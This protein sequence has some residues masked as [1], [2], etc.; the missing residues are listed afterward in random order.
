MAYSN[1]QY[2][3]VNNNKNIYYYYYLNMDCLY[4]SSCKICVSNSTC[5]LKNK[6]DKSQYKVYCTNLDCL[7]K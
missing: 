5:T 3:Y 4:L 6:T 2:G 7:G 1:Y